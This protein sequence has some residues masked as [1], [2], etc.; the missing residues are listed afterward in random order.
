MV[1]LAAAVV[2]SCFGLPSLITGIGT[3]GTG[4]GFLLSGLVVIAGVFVIEWVYMRAVMH[5]NNRQ[6]LYLIR[7]AE[8]SQERL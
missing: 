7:Q 8:E 2:N 6:L 3:I 4:T 1:P 5:L